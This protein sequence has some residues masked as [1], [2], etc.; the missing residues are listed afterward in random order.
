MT[1]D[2]II[3]GAGP[4][5][6]ELAAMLASAGESVV[7]IERDQLGGTCLNRGCIPTKCLCATADA[8]SAVSRAAAFGVTAQVNGFDYSVARQRV[9]SVINNLRSGIEY[10]L[11]GVQI[12]RGEGKLVTSTTVAVGDD[13]YIASKRVVIAT[14]ST[15]AR[16][17]IPGAD[18]C[19]DSTDVLAMDSLP[20]SMVIIGG[21]VIGMEFASIMNT[22]GVKTTV[23]E[24]CPEVLPMIDADIAKRL[25]QQLSR[26]GIDF[27]VGAA[28]TTVT[29]VDDNTLSVSADT[30]KG[31][32]TIEAEK[33]VMAVGRRPVVPQG[34]AEVGIKL[35]HRG[36]IVADEN[37]CT[38]V[39]GIYAIGDVNG[40][41]MLAHSA[42]AQGRVIALG[43][44]Q[45]FN[46][47]CV[48][49][50]VFTS[51]EVATVGANTA[52]LDRDGVSYK[53]VK[54]QFSSNGKAN[55]EGHTDGLVKMLVADDD[56]ILGITILGHHAADLI[57]EATVLVTDHVKYN[58]VAR[59][60]I[61][62]HPTLSE[63]FL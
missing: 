21:G 58:D 30:K 50:V 34:T 52:T 2:N 47:S 55:A 60:Y 63:I 12:V 23:V 15:T 53:V 40:K 45:A 14:G 38:S 37:M 43:D 33:V 26:Q 29:R 8:L 5:G 19:I 54:H 49:S 22:F 39:P 13:T 25:R 48:P 46:A 16:L 57:A 11:S 1:V 44:T 28:V 59:R 3:I 32:V 41:S 6:Y 31:A 10:Q 51:P 24:F 36:F 7:I 42:I 56:S 61:H 62:A 20:A 27:K 17:P 18:L 9:D 35:D 4:G